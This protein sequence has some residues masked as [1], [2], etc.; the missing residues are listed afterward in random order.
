[1]DGRSPW[2]SAGCALVALTVALPAPEAGAQEGVI[3]F[4]SDRWVKRNAEVVEHAGRRSLAGFAYLDGVELSNGVIEVDV[5]VPEAGVRSYPGIVFR[6]ESERDYERV[7]L[8]PHR[9][10][11]YPDAIQYTPVMNGIAGWQLYNGEGFTAAAVIPAGEWVHLRLEVAGEQAR[12]WLGDAEE[13]ALAIHH[14]KRGASTGSVGIMGPT[15]GTAY[16]SN[17]TYGEDA[18]LAFDPVPEPGMPPGTITEWEISQAFTLGD[19]DLEVP[20]ARQEGL[21]IEW[22]RVEPDHTG[23]V[24]VARYTGRLGREPDCIFARTT[25]EGDAGDVVRL[26]FGYSDAISI[27][28]NGKLL[29]T[30]SSAYTQR[31]PS[32]L[33][34]IGYFDAVY[35]PLRE[36]DND[37]SVIVTESFGGWAFMCRDGNAVFTADGVAG[38]WE[39]GGLLTPECVAYDPARG[40][41]YVSNF[42]GYQRAGPVGAQYVSRVSLTGE[43]TE[44]R[45]IT[46]LAMPTGMAVSGGTLYVVERAS[47][48]EID[49][50]SASV[51]ARHPIPD[52]RFPNDV[53]VDGAGRVYVSDSAASVIYR[54]ADGA[55]EAWLDSGEV[56]S[57]NALLVDGGALL[58]GSTGDRRLK[59][60]DLE[61]R[62]VSTVAEF[63]PGNIDGI[64]VDG[65]GGYLVSQWEGVVYR[66]DRTGS[67]ERILDT[68]VAGENCADFAYVESERLLVVPT[69]RGDRL[70]AY[71]LGN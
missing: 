8:R 48:V 68:T 50:E 44:P 60:I 55:F 56:S 65:H 66:A 2:G 15:D 1:M 36:G 54:F 70:A 12:L 33:G 10:P 14:L 19:V 59:S 11:L 43:V 20:P 42:D 21:A 7:Y 29:F 64:Q 47:L 22:S 63:P 25:I 17:F 71:R 46:G 61:T 23:L 41:L 30:G 39:A 53:A 49:I 57:P 6:L 26:E 34:V 28:L 5:I 40:V 37:L 67:A 3:D 18:G 45:W 24:D 69:F 9:A 32:F 4:D 51:V 13:P 62:E 27:F 35:L 52:A 31:D 16:F 38:T 58:V